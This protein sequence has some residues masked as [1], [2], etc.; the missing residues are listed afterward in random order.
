MVVAERQGV[1]EKARRVRKPDILGRDVVFEYLRDAGVTHLF[2]VPGTNEIPII[3]GTK[4]PNYQI[5]YVPC[6]HENIAM[7]AAMGYARTSG[8]PGVVELHVTPGIGHGLGN[9]FNAAKSRIPI[10]VLCGQQ[11]SELLLQEPLLASDLVQVARQ[12]TKWA[13]EIRTADELP[14]AMQRALKTA[15]TP[16]QGPVFLSIPWEFTIAPVNFPATPK[17][18]KVATGAAGEPG[19]VKQAAERLARAKNPVIVVGDGAGAADAWKELAALAEVIGAPVY[20]EQLSSYLSFP[21]SDYHW[22]GELPGSQAEM[23]H[24]LG[25]H[26]V[27]FLCG[28]NGQAQVVVFK[29]SDGPLIPEKVA[30]VYLHNDPW[31]IGKN[32]YGE[33]AILGDIKATLP[34]I[35]KQITKVSGYD[36]AKATERDRHL[37]TLASN[38]D[39]QLK[40]FAEQLPAIHQGKASTNK[41]VVSGVQIAIELRKLQDT[42]VITKPLTLINE[43]ISDTP[44]FQTYV[45]YDSP[46]SYMAAEGGSLGYSMP[47]SLGVKIAVGDSRTVI[48]AVGDGSTLFYPHT[49]WTTFGQRLPILYLITN[50]L[51]YRTLL[52]GLSVIESS[53][54][55]MP[56]GDPDYLRLDQ[57][58]VDFVA[59]ATAFGI[60]AARVSQPGELAEKLAT[61]VKK[62]EDRK[63]YVLEVRTDRT[64]YPPAPLG[65]GGRRGKAAAGVP[66]FPRLDVYFASKG[67]SNEFPALGPV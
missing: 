29:W 30:Q 65:N 46:R 48:N 20:L 18:T 47:A 2:G 12:Y 28:F 58:P 38:R 16:P 14:M 32:Y 59:L 43:A 36:R 24:K 6:L 42:G 51:E 15:L 53:Y 13:Y 67:G 25:L 35:T 11:H 64:V 27:A 33:T 57:N 44:S 52:K 61:A 63:P 5:T 62:V 37:Q 55:W 31:E 60:E 45:K 26:D 21:N 7:G 56:T 34:L 66:A 54:Q 23:S 1:R 10:V 17:I 8:K 39:G 22:Q 50:N 9:L 4:D 41:A 19:A 49:W 40:K 3:D